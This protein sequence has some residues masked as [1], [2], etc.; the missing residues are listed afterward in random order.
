MRKEHGKAVVEVVARH[1]RRELYIISSG[2]EAE[3][4]SGD[5]RVR[6]W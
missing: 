6:S 3:C 4:I 2:E 5:K 1:V